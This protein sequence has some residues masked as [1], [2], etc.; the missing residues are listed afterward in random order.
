M[1]VVAIL[2]RN[3]VF[4]FLSC[5]LPHLRDKGSRL[6]ANEVR[7]E[8]LGERVYRAIGPYRH[9]DQVREAF[10]SSEVGFKTKCVRGERKHEES[11]KGTRQCSGVK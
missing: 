4:S 3:I 9:A 5:T 7:S 1:P 11:R 2:P 10:H 8:E 6:D